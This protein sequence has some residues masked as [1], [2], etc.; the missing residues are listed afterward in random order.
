MATTIEAI[1]RASMM[2]IGVLGIG[3]PL[4]A[5]EGSDALKIF[6]QMVDSWSNENLLIPIQKVVTK[7]LI[8][9]VSEYTIGVYPGVPIPDNHIETARPVQILS[10]Y[11]Y[12]S[13]N[14]SY[15][16]KVM[17]LKEYDSISVKNTEA[18]PSR[19]YVRKGWP[20]NTIIF[21]S[22]PYA[23]ETLNMTVIQPLIELLPVAFLTE[24]VNLPPGYEQVLIDNLSIMLAP[25]WGQQIS[26][27]VATMAIEGKKLIKR[28]N[29]TPSKLRCDRGVL[30]SGSYGNY[31]INQGI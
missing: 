4:P 9:G 17:D 18:V 31:D 15:Q 20:L 30:S 24:E 8:N 29:K 11:L 19:M 5:D 6:R 25:I 3:E 13:A 21:D 1:I 23:A 7:Q 14:T 16:L 26:P 2:K 27:A 22:Y 12:D 28:A 10:S